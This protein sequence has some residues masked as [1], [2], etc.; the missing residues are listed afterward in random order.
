MTTTTATTLCA[1]EEADD[2]K[3][4]LAART[5]N[6]RDVNEVAYVVT[7][8]AVNTTFSPHARDWNH[9]R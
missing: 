9:P 6:A 3:H 1:R 5:S 2:N 8:A 4:A 7:D